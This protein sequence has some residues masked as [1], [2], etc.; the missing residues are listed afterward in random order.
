MT[1]SF[2]VALQGLIQVD[3]V[4]PTGVHI[5]RP[6]GG[7]TGPVGLGGPAGT[8]SFIELD[9]AVVHVFRLVSFL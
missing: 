5:G 6:W 7:P 8:H 4:G 9:K 3:P 2:W 1:H